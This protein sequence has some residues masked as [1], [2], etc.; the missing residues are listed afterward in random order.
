MEIIS[1][2]KEWENIVRCSECA[3]DLKV[4]KCDLI[5]KNGGSDHMGRGFPIEDMIVTVVCPRCNSSIEI[6]KTITSGIRATLHET[7]MTQQP[8][9]WGFLSRR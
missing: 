8:G 9:Y 7:L 4:K 6:T 5:A 2:S 3:A 1:G